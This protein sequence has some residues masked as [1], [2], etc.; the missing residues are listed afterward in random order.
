VTSQVVDN[1]FASSGG[2]SEIDARG[3]ST[4]A[5]L[6]LRVSTATARTGA[7]S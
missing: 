4:G 2:E 7:P 5:R 6:A 1:R 3:P